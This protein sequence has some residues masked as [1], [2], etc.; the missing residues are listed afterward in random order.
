VCSSGSKMVD[1]LFIIGRKYLQAID[2]TLPSFQYSIQIPLFY[3]F[4]LAFLQYVIEKGKNEAYSRACISRTGDRS[5]R[6]CAAQVGES[7]QTLL[8]PPP[9]P[10]FF[11]TGHR[12]LLRS[13]KSPSDTLVTYNFETDS[14]SWDVVNLTAQGYWHKDPAFPQ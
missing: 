8:T 10:R 14:T 2:N 12:F 6:R 5:V 13:M 3:F 7:R 4:I 9:H 1:E 11:R